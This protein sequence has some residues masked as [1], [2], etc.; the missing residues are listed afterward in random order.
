VGERK[1][2]PGGTIP[3]TRRAKPALSWRLAPLVGPLN[4]SSPHTSC[5]ASLTSRDGVGA[6]VLDVLEVSRDDLRRK[7][8]AFLPSED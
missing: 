2:T 7:A 6:Q 3:F 1:D 4:R 5:S 8:K